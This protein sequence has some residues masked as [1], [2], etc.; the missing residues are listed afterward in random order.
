[1][2]RVL[3]CKKDAVATVVCNFYC[4][5]ITSGVAGTTTDGI[6]LQTRFK[7]KEV[8][9]I[10]TAGI[11]SRWRCEADVVL[12]TETYFFCLQQVGT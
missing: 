10:D 11:G 9:L 3:G 6:E 8:R 4:S 7:E 1:M 12:Q 2:S 5:A